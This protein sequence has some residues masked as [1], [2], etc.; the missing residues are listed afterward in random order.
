[1][2]QQLKSVHLPTVTEEATGEHERT[3]DPEY[4]DKE[5]SP[6]AA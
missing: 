6:N 2:W 3:P 4:G 1:M 5:F